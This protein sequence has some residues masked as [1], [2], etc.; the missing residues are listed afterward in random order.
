MV[1]LGA[2]PRYGLI[3]GSGVQVQGDNRWMVETP[4]GPCLLAS[5]D[6]ERR[7]IFA[8]RH[9]CTKINAEG[10]AEYA[11]PHEADS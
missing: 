3:G 1:I 8:N 11:P 9:L 10:K 7:I 6:D 5:L 2:P 4:F